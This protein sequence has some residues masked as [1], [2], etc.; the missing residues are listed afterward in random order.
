MFRSWEITL[1]IFEP[2]SKILDYLIMLRTLNNDE[3][4]L[5][6]IVK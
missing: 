6:S 5:K 3:C 1:W 4:L 2:N